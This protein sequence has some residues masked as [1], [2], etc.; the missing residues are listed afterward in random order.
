MG[1]RWLARLGGLAI[2]FILAA[3]GSGAPATSSVLVVRDA[4]DRV[5]ARVELPPSGAFAL[6]YRNSLYGSIAEERFTAVDGVIRLRELAADDLAVLEEYYAI[7]RA[8]TASEP[9]DRRA[10]RAAPALEVIEERI[11][12]AA[13]DLGERALLVS[14]TD[15]I[16]LWR[17]A[18]DADPMLTIEVEP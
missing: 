7:D 12:L 1:T 8:A 5:V 10:W 9:L 16:E 2:V 17:L 3:C 18:P 4:D 11:R 14:G 13:T 6:R 15:P